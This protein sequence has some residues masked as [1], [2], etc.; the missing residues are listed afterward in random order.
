MYKELEKADFFLTL[1]DPD[2]SEHDR[3]ITTGTSG[4]FQLI[5][6]F[7][8]PCLINKKFA[9]LHGFNEENSIIYEK[10]SDFTEALKKAID[11]SANDYNSMQ[12]SLKIY[13]DNL[14]QTSL[15]DLKE[16]LEW[17]IN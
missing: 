3:Y 12:N 8:K 4:S 1:L 11:M 10:N 16:V 7:A 14:Y 13:A 6:G 15:K 17:E 2:N 5:Y 9:A